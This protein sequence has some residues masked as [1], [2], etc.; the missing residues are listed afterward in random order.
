MNKG[1]SDGIDIDLEWRPFDR[2]YPGKIHNSGLAGTIGG[3]VV[4]ADYSVLRSYVDDFARLLPD[5]VT[6]NSLCTKK[7][8]FQIHTENAIPLL[9][10]DLQCGPGDINPSV[11]NEDIDLSEMFEAFVDHSLNAF[12]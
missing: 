2:Q 7:D 9:F 12:E 8:T 10:G 4:I 5:H 6:P 3:T 1:R 11:V